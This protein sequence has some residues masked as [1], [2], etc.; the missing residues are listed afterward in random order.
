MTLAI[1]R[2]DIRM[3][4]KQQLHKLQ[5]SLLRC[6]VQWGSVHLVSG[7]HLRTTSKKELCDRT[8]SLVSCKM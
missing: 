7:I 2:K 6:E 8:L 5:M 1:E 3:V 4:F